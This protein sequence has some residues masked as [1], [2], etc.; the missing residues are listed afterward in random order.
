MYRDAIFQSVND[1]IGLIL[2]AEGLE[3]VE[4]QLQPQKGRW[5][6]RVYV[7]AE[8]GVSLEDCRLASLEIGQVLDA[9]DLIPA[10]Y[11]LEV[12]SPG[13]DRPLHTPRDFRRHN[14]RLVTVFLRTPVHG[15]TQHTGRVVAVTTDDL[16]LHT[17]SEEPLEIPLSQVDHGVVELE[18]K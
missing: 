11:R 9:E 7:D 1:T 18:F 5:L 2:E 16:V 6:V 4:L 15:A 10:S 3:L 14:Q 8:H 13:L 12:S 17:P